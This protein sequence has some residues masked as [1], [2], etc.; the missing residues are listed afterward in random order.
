MDFKRFEKKSFIKIRKRP[1]IKKLDPFE[2]EYTGETFLEETSMQLFQFNKDNYTENKEFKAADVVGFPESGSVY[3][4]NIH[5][6]HDV[7]L[8]KNICFKLG[9]H[10]L[11][12][13][14]ILD[15]NQ[16]PKLQEFDE[17]IFFSV[18][19]IL[20]TDTNELKVEQI[21]FI[22]G[23]NYVL[24]FQEKPADYFEHIRQRIREYKG[25]A[26]ERTADFLLY[27]LLESILDN[28]YTTLEDL[29]PKIYDLITIDESDPEPK[30][31]ADIENFKKQVLQLKRALGP[32]YDAISGI[33]KGISGKVQQ[34]HLK[35]FYD[36]KDQSSQS[37]ENAEALIQRLDSGI[38]LF[39]SL[40]G[41]RMNQVMKTLTIVTSIFIPLSFIAGVY[42][43]N[44]T[45]MPELTWQYG[46]FVVL[47]V[48]VALIVG[49]LAFFKKQK[50]F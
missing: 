35:Y 29:E 39:F 50:W 28:Y 25:L 8:I 47:G 46:Y 14:D 2:F 17:Y 12:V 40:Q 36:L 30:L 22:L 7:E 5:G 32:F 20:P 3:W 16:R 19:S 37:L 10:R 44:F 11:V 23:N 31:I 4:L 41:H 24:S 45:N 27:L 6:I 1:K 13:Q 42:G 9:I 43:M 33:E 34:K 15:T 49:M 26:R 38:N 48:M 18:K 21:S